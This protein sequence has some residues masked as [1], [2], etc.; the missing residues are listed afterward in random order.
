VVINA[1]SLDQPANPLLS[2]LL[3]FGQTVL[4]LGAFF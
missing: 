2:L 1:R 3:G 4:L